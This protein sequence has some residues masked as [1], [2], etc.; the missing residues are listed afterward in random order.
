MAQPVV[1]FPSPSMQSQIHELAKTLPPP[2]KQNTACDA[3]RTRKVKCHRIPGQEKC[4]VIL[5]PRFSHQPADRL[6]SIVSPR[7]SLARSHFVQQATSEKKRTSSAARRP[8]NISTASPTSPVISSS[9]IADTGIHSI[10]PY[11]FPSS[12]SVLLLFKYGLY[13]PIT[14]ESSTRYVLS[15]IFAPPEEASSDPSLFQSPRLNS[16]YA[17]WGELAVKLEDDG[18]KA[19]LAFDLTE[20]YFQIVHSRLPLLNP[21]EFRDRLKA[22]LSPNLGSEKNPLHPALVAT[23]IAWGT[24]FSEHTLLIADRKAHNGQSAMSKTLINR[25]RDLAE[26]LKVHRIP[27]QDHVVIGLLLETLQSQNPDDPSSFHGFWLTA[28]TRHLL[29]LGINHKSVAAQIDNPEER[30][31]LIFAWWMTCI[32]DAYSSLY[33][34][35][36][37]LLDDDDYDIDFYTADP[38]RSDGAP[39]PREQLEFLGY[40]RAAHSLARTARQMS[41]QLWRPVTDVDGIPFETLRS[42][43]SELRR[44]RDEYLSRVGVPKTYNAAWDFVT[45]VSCFA[46]DAQYHVMWIILFNAL[47]EFGLKEINEHE[48]GITPLGN[49]GHH[50]EESVKRVA[51]EALNGAL[52][53]SALTSV[54]T[55]NEY[56]KLDPAVVEFHIIAAGQLLARLGRAEASTC[57]EG[58]EQY[59]RSYEEAGDH[60]QEIRKLLEQ[61]HNGVLDLSHMAGVVKDIPELPQLT[62]EPEI[63]PGGREPMSPSVLGSFQIMNMNG[64]GGLIG[65]DKEMILAMHNGQVRRVHDG[66]R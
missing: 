50:I 46:S 21:T 19:E 66:Q 37:P 27:H 62:T 36:K 14:R 64:G 6:F 31:T 4:Q 26:A 17:T 38:V 53:I 61:A 30:G 16:P 43:A 29:D 44:W 58:L 63:P 56:L 3:C 1:N 32:C 49:I 12:P 25:A 34:R 54:L 48:R 52:R 8:R 9:P 42:F 41:R 20:I 13:P 55:A 10:P 51:E 39:S 5:S 45:T 57:I 22:S 11:G 23:V 60:A 35:H 59:S 33:Y 65:V 40:Y 47:D 15:Y 28:A 7:I 18:F 2:R 24:K